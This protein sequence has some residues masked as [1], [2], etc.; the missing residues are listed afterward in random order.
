VDRD[1]A[2][3]VVIPVGPFQANRRWL[4]EALGSAEAQGDFLAEILI[5]DDMA[6]LGAGDFPQLL[7]SRVRLWESPWRLGVAHAFNF[8]VALSRST[9]VFM[10]GSDDK[11][12]P[13]CLEACWATYEGENR[14]DAFYGVGVQYSDERDD[15]YLPC[16]AAMVTKKFWKQTGGFPVE[17]AVG[18]PDAAFVSMLLVN[19]KVPDPILVNR[20]RPLYWYRVHGESDT[21]QRAAWQPTILAVRDLVT[22]RVANR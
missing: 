12:L 5:I 4:N 11:L 17:T 20:E 3:T 7:H 8:G 9:C 10:L 15:Q 1:D 16:N 2:I 14:L 19:D 13:G 6:H 21:A 22:Q 18:A